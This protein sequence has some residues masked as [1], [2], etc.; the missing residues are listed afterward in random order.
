M[1]IGGGECALI[2]WKMG[3]M[4][5]KVWTEKHTYVR[6]TNSVYHGKLLILFV[7]CVFIV[8]VTNTFEILPIE[9][10]CA[11]KRTRTRLV[12]FN[13]FERGLKSTFFIFAPSRTLR[14]DPFLISLGLSN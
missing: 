1:E 9:T 5:N 3:R 6:S 14:T 4:Q 12:E 13:F 10:D 11:A 2:S 7:K 8:S